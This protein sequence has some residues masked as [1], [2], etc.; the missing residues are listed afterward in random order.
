MTIAFPCENCGN[1]F[2][3]DGALAGK[4]CR[5]KKCGH[6]FV[7]P[8]PHRPAGTPAPPPSPSPSRPPLRTFD[9]TGQATSPDGARPR[10]AAPTPR[11]SRL[12]PPPRPKPAPA[13]PPVPNFLDDDDPY[14][15]GD[16]PAPVLTRLGA[17]PPGADEEFLPPRG[18]KPAPSAPKKKKKKRTA[19][20]WFENVPGW[21]WLAVVGTYGLLFLLALASSTMAGVF[22]V[23]MGLTIVGLY[24]VGGIGMLVVP[25]RES[26]VCGLLYLFLPFYAL[27]YLIT[28]WQ[29]MRPWFLTS[30]SGVGLAVVS[31]L[32]LPAVAPGMRAGAGPGLPAAAGGGRGLIGQRADVGSDIEPMLVEIIETAEEQCR[33]LESVTDEASARAAAPR[34]GELTE[35]NLRLGEQLKQRNAMND[36]GFIGNVTLNLKYGARLNQVKERLEKDVKQLQSRPE[37]QAI[38]IRQASG[39]GLFTGIGQP[40]GAPAPRQPLAPP[41]VPGLPGGSPP[42]M[43]PFGQRAELP[44]PSAPPAPAPADDSVT[45]VVSGLTDQETSEVFGQKLGE[46][47]KGAGPRTGFRSIGGG[48]RA[49]YTAWPVRDP[50][51]FAERVRLFARVTRVNG[52]TLTVE[53]T[54]LRPGERRP[55][56]S[57]AVA[58]MLFDLKSPALQ[59]RKDALG[60]LMRLPADPSRRAEVSRAI[61]P[62]LKDADGFGR[63]DAA[64]ALAVW[65]GPENTPALAAALKDPEFGVRWAVLDTFKALHDPAGAEAV[66]ACLLTDRGKAVEALRAMGSE[67]EPAVLKYL[68]HND[69]GVRM[70]VCKLLREIGSDACVP[71]LYDLLRKNNGQGLDSMAASEALKTLDP[72]GKAI[73]RGS[74]KAVRKR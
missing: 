17:P 57:D 54:P 6:V 13:P 65:G 26:V 22:A 61:E 60:R 66:A 35:K 20:S 68:D 55:P 15:I 14:A 44:P 19:G 67:A 70:D 47:L 5:C 1:R 51:A 32:L 29:D 46:A 31:A 2:E 42:G 10:A 73:R 21:A 7:I 25:F 16:E 69:W 12:D 18:P 58:Q 49:T 41:A 8:V 50:Q 9:S 27:Y 37:L 72:D 28:R 38:F 11:T 71:A 30:L 33:L 34:Y 62:M 36:L 4:K 59:R 45:L 53:M 23:V 43:P 3:V 24:L 48:G 39:S 64:K 52:R 56:D 74:K 63:S 40:P